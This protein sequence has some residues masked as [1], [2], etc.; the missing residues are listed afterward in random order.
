MDVAE[1]VKSVE[2]LDGVGVGGVGGDDLDGDTLL[3]VDGD[4]GGLVGGV[5]GVL[6]HGPHVGGGSVVR[7][8][9]DTCGR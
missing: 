8:L 9:Q 5:H 3:E 1:L 4:V 2:E 6:S 7:V